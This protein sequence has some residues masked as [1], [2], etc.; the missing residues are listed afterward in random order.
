MGS[1][2]MGTDLVW[3]PTDYHLH[4]SIRHNNV[5]S[6][7]HRT[8]GNSTLNHITTQCIRISQKRLSRPPYCRYLVTHHFDRFREKPFRWI[9][10]FRFYVDC[11][12]R[13]WVSDVV[14][15]RKV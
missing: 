5:L 11:R 1:K 6:S 12:G 15:G 2:K 14:M 7:S 13:S 10:G 9:E 8:S 3:I 4:L